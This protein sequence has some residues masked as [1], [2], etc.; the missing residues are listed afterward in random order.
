MNA[1]I[2]GGV[3]TGGAQWGEVFS[4]GVFSFQFSVLSFQRFCHGTEN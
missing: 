3:E 4:G 2:E 1:M